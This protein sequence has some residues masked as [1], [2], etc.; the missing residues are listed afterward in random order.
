MGMAQEIG[1]V[2]DTKSKMF[3]VEGLMKT[4][5]D[6]DLKTSDL[7]SLEVEDKNLVKRATKRLAVDVKVGESPQ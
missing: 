3:A 4:E 1:A 2:L 6:K 7:I 5:F